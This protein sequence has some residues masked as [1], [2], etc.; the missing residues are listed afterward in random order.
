MFY[1]SYPYITISIHVLQFMLRYISGYVFGLMLLFYG[2][3]SIRTGTVYFLVGRGGYI[4]ERVGWGNRWR[5][6][7]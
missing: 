5:Y 3:D 7:L 6:I 1:N 2:L 4:V